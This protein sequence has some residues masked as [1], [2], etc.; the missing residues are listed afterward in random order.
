M[1]KCGNDCPYFLRTYILVIRN[2]LHVPWMN[3]N[4]LPPF[5]LREE[6]VEVNETPKIHVK[7]ITVEHHSIYLRDI[8]LR[9]PLPLWGVFLYFPS[10]KPTSDELEACDKV[11]LTPDS[12][13]WDPHSDVFS[14]NEENHL[15]WEGNV[16]KRKFRKR[17]LI[18]DDDGEIHVMSV[19]T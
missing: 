9:I 3:H 8:N 14:R 2:E 17:I 15:D 12:P 16:V 6:G 11:I 7:N 19:L 4:L 5:I 18:G 10:R 1:R 13:A